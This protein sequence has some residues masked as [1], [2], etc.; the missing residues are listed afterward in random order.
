MNE[1][2]NL[3]KESDN[4][5]T[6]LD[7]LNLL[8]KKKYHII[9]IFICITLLFF[10][11]GYFGN[12]KNESTTVISKN[13]FITQQI[14]NLPF[15]IE[16]HYFNKKNI[17]NLFNEE[18]S[19]LVTEKEIINNFIMVYSDDKVG[20]LENFDLRL[21]SQQNDI[22]IF[23]KYDENI[24]PEPYYVTNDFAYYIFLQA[25]KN[26]NDLIKLTYENNFNNQIKYFENQIEIAKR[27]KIEKPVSAIITD[28]H[29]FIV[30]VEILEVQKNLYEEQVNDLIKM[31]DINNSNIN[32][33]NLKNT[34]DN[35]FTEYGERFF[36]NKSDKDTIIK[37]PN[38][39]NLL[40]ISQMI[41]L[42]ISILYLF[43]LIIYKK[44]IVKNF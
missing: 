13:N 5:V 2:K 20:G 9:S 1:T 15:L 26:V 14:F 34:F 19:R 11:Y 7:F 18:I 27:S 37:T 17:R 29:S 40:L 16:N 36:I 24:R 43:F 6:F 3:I 30:G 32:Y 21:N 4:Q 28:P 25:Y 33:E 23:F 42:T 41:S 31:H 12:K 44:L 38:I 22:K 10:S 8:S 35:I 39:I